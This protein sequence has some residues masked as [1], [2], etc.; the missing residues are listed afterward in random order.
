MEGIYVYANIEIDK[1]YPG[2]HRPQSWIDEHPLFVKLINKLKKSI[3]EEG[4]RHPLCAVNLKDDGTYEVTTGNRRL[5][6][7]QEIKA[8]TVPCVVACK[9]GQE[10]IPQGKVLRTE[11]EILE[12]YGGSVK[13]ICLNP[14]IFFV[15]PIEDWD[16][17]KM[18]KE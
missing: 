2:V 12:Q 4:L 15:A 11:K 17:H 13:N 14:N 5:I 18:F 1:L 6:A 9:P 3:E 8:E 16:E 7:L 10:F